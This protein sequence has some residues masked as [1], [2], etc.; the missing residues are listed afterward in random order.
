MIKGEN[1]KR[2]SMKPWSYT[3]ER[4]KVMAALY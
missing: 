4:E 1:S 2:K 3:T